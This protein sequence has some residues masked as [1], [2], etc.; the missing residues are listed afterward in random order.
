MWGIFNFK[1]KSYVRFNL[2]QY[3]S[4]VY[5]RDHKA[6]PHVLKLK[7]SFD[8]LRLTLH[9]LSSKLHDTTQARPSID[10]HAHQSTRDD[11]IKVPTKN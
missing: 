9:I 7:A 1:L 10:T 3:L 5:Y 2:I 4:F 8:F 6:A 11:Y